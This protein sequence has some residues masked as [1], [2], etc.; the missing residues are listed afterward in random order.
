MSLNS[1]YSIW[2][3]GSEFGVN[4]KAFVYL[5]LYQWFRLLV[6]EWDIF[7]THFGSLEDH[8]SAT[9]CPCTVAEHVHPFMIRV[10]AGKIVSNQVLASFDLLLQIM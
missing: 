10:S 4:M 5:A 2:M 9:A 1:Y 7:L 8:L 3:I 6:V